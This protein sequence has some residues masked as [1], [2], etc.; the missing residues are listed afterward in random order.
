MDIRGTIIGANLYKRERF[1]I[2]QRASKRREI[3]NSKRRSIFS[4]TD[5]ITAENTE[6]IPVN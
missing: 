3:L 4:L 6:T 5:N 2:D 1:A